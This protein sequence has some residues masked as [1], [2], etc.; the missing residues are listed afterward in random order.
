MVAYA[1]TDEAPEGQKAKYMVVLNSTSASVLAQE[2]IFILTDANAR[3]GKRNGGSEETDIVVLSACGRDVL[4]ES[5]ARFR[6]RQKDRSSE[7]FYF[8]P[9]EVVCPTRSKAPTAARDRHV[10]T[11]S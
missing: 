4:K 10:W 8:A 11:L 2:Y 6:R 7:H 5:T 9:S 1:P 3:T